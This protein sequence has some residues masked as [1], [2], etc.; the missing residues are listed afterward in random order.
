MPNGNTVHDEYIAEWCDERHRKL[1]DCLGEIKA[2][3][4]ETTKAVEGLTKEVSVLASKIPEV[5]ASQT[6]LWKVILYLLGAMIAGGSGG[7]AIQ[8]AV[9][10]ADP[11]AQVTHSEQD[12]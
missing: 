12:R 3:Q 10:A 4:K 2:G 11:P 5:Q 9:S 7:A 1:D 6:K 8:K